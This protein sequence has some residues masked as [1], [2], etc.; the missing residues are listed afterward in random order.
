MSRQDAGFNLLEIMAVIALTAIGSSIAVIHMKLDKTVQPLA[1]DTRV[2][3]RPRSALGLKYIELTPGHSKK[4]FKQ[5][6]HVTFAFNANRGRSGA[7]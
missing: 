2:L 6:D 3:V 7:S 1:S 5:G 4:T